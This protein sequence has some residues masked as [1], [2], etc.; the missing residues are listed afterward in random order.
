MTG[1]QMIRHSTLGLE[2]EQEEPEEDQDI[3]HI[4]NETLPE[5][6][7]RFSEGVHHLAVLSI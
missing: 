3:K 5:P 6:E 1:W 7:M 2:M 4:Q